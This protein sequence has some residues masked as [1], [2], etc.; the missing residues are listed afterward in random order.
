MKTGILR[1]LTVSAALLV[2]VSP[3]LAHHFFPRESDTPVSITGTVRKFEMVNPHSRVL[4]DVRDAAGTVTTW[5]IELG[6][7]PALISRGWSRDTLKPGDVVTGH[8][9]AIGPDVVTVDIGY[10]SEGRIPLHEFTNREG[11]L[12]VHDEEL[13]A[14]LIEPA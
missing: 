8:V 1:V 11:E 5:S 2:L 10:K 12:L 9:V 14:R 13:L 7:V 6:S 3:V 4:L